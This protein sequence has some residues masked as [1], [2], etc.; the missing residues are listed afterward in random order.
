VTPDR[1]AIGDCAQSIRTGHV[2]RYW[3]THEVEAT[4][5]GA[6]VSAIV[7]WEAVEPRMAPPHVD[8]ALLRGRVPEDVIDYCG[9]C[10]PRGWLRWAEGGRIERDRYA[11]RYTAD[12]GEPGE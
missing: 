4:I 8:R 1:L 12:L 6:R 10:S 7:A 9:V 11:I 5:G 3:G 2:R